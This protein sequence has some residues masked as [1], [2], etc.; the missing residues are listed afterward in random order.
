MDEPQSAARSP[1]LSSR[2]RLQRQA[3]QW[4]LWFVPG[5]SAGTSAWQWTQRNELRRV[6]DL[7][8]SL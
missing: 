3:G 2:C 5:A 7:A 4:F 8:R 1:G 6:G